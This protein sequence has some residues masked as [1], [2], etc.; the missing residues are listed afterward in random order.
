VRRIPYGGRIPSRPVIVCLAFA[1]VV[2]SVVI[3]R[4]GLH[5]VV[6]CGIGSD[7]H[8]SQTAEDW[9]TYADHVVVA[10]PTRERETGR[11]DLAQGPYRYETDRTV[12][13]RTDDVL[14]SAARPGRP[15]GE[16]FDMVAPGWR[17][18]R[19][20]GNRIKTTNPNAP[21][22]ETGHTYLLA[23]RW[24]DDGWIVLGEGAAVPFDDR[25]GD[26]G[27]WC[28]RVLSKEDVARGERFSRLDDHSL[29]KA[30]LGRNEQAVTRELDRAS[31]TRP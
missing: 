5:T 17:A 21:R 12:T 13:F 14:W 15:M 24:S 16:D 11:R 20:S 19:E 28:G 2:A 4:P 22:L 1:G 26:Q 30:A 25:T 10:T 7:E 8:P 23:L 9:V 27:E 3:G 18:Y 29:E 31:G 6:G